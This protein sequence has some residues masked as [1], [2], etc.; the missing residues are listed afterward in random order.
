MLP[1]LGHVE[2][3]L[4]DWADL[5]TW[6]DRLAQHPAQCSDH[7]A[8][9]RVSAAVAPQAVALAGVMSALAG[10]KHLQLVRFA[11]DDSSSMD[12]LIAALPLL[13]ALPHLPALSVDTM[14]C[15]D[16]GRLLLCLSSTLSCMTQLMRLS[17][18]QLRAVPFDG[19]QLP[20]LRFLDLAEVN[21][22]LDEL[23]DLPMLTQLHY[24]HLEEHQLGAGASHKMQGAPFVVNAGWVDCFDGL[25][26]REVMIDSCV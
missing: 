10:S 13:T 26:H 7:T 5:H 14:C 4:P 22:N 3:A 18:C 25:I 2:Q 11:T 21:T 1:D 15:N 24:L 23:D 20:D 19:V 8:S 17:L 12:R 6:F 16:D 9:P